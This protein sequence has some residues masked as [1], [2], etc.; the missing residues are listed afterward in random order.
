MPTQ[1]VRLTERLQLLFE[2]VETK[3]HEAAA[4]VVNKCY[5]T[6]R[7]RRD[8]MDTYSLLLMHCILEALSQ[9]SDLCWT[10]K[11]RK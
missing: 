6:L 7:S 10:F 5:R 1:I 8:V 2:H 9:Y 3:R 4:A 11:R